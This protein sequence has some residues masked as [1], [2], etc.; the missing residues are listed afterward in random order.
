MQSLRI[1]AQGMAGVVYGQIFSFGVSE[2]FKELVGMFIPGLPLFCSA[3]CGLTGLVVSPTRRRDNASL[4]LTAI[5]HSRH[6]R[7]ARFVLSTVCSPFRY[8]EKSDARDKRDYPE[9]QGTIISSF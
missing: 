8:V 3:A 6:N 4:R 5:C 2:R 9:G 1:L 7:R